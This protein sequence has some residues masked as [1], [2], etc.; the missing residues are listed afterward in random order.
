MGNSSELNTDSVNRR[1]QNRA[2]HHTH[3]DAERQ[4]EARRA[5]TGSSWEKWKDSRADRW[6]GR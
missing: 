5:T 6:P 4:R 1:V 3:D 2:V